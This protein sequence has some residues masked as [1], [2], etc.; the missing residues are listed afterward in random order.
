MK[1]FIRVVTTKSFDEQQSLRRKLNEMGFYVLSLPDNVLEVNVIE[2][3]VPIETKIFEFLTGGSMKKERK[4]SY[5]RFIRKCNCCNKKTIHVLEA[6]VTVCVE[7][8]ETTQ[9]D[10]DLFGNEEKE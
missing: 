4:S 2:E 9:D 7:C 8:N 5:E 6:T 1:K 3:D 10:S